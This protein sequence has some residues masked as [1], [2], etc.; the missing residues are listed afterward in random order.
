MAILCQ[1]GAHIVRY[2]ALPKDSDIDSEVALLQGLLALDAAGEVAE[3][4]NDVEGLVQ[5]SAMW[6]KFSETIQGFA[7]AAGQNISI[8]GGPKFRTGFQSGVQEEITFEEEQED[9]GIEASGS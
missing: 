8:S 2:K 6:M 1:F 5:V 9:G 4:L 3:K 7:E